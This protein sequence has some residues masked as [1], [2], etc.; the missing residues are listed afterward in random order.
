M[1]FSIFYNQYVF[2]QCK[3]SF[4]L[5]ILM[6]GKDRPTYIFGLTNILHIS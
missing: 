1:T 4:N 2:K 6:S 5:L 3:K